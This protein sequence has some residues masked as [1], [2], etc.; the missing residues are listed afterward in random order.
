MSLIYTFAASPMEG[1]P[2]RKIGS[3]LP[4]DSHYRCGGNE[5]VLFTGA[6]GPLNARETAALAFSACSRK[7]EKNPDLALSIGLC[8]GL[9]T[10]MPEGAVVAY[11]ECLST[12][13][14]SSP[15]LCS[16]T[17]TNSVAVLL[18][19]SGIHV[20]RLFGIAWP[21]IASRPK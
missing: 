6:M 14:H 18:E 19:A 7:S 2:V 1:E 11:E 15:L 20:G 5:V 4:V 17:L 9:S 21:R 8:G 13:D 10:L 12:E 3:R 16:S